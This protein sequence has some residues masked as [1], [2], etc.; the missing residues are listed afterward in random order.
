MASPPQPRR[1]AFGIA[2]PLLTYV[3][4]FSKQLGRAGLEKLPRRSPLCGYAKAVSQLF[5]WRHRDEDIIPGQG[6]G[7]AITTILN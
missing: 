3:V 6:K 5:T 1:G 4:V 2:L 7:L